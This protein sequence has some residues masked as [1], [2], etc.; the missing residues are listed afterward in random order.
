[1]SSYLSKKQVESLIPHREPMLF[2]DEVLSYEL[3]KTLHGKRTFSAKDPIFD[4]HF[5]GHPVLP[6]VLIIES[7]AQASALLVNLTLSKT[8][9]ETIFYF[10]SIDSSKFRSPVLPNQEINLYVE[11][12]KQR[13]K[14]FK[15]NCIAKVAEKIVAETSITAK[16]EEK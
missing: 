12:V 8:A 11:L 3:G 2:V 14:I 5:P 9:E 10:M 4:G 13:G 1:M 15:F 16:L 6:G 7:L